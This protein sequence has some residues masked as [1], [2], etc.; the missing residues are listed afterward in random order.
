MLKTLK[1][2]LSVS[3]VFSL[4]FSALNFN[5]IKVFAGKSKEVRGEA[6]LNTI[7]KYESKIPEVYKLS[8]ANIPSGVDI[9]NKVQVMSL[10]AETQELIKKVEIQKVMQEQFK[11]AYR[12]G[13]LI[14]KFNRDESKDSI[15]EIVK[16]VGIDERSLVFMPT[17]RK[18]GADKLKNTVILKNIP[19]AD[20]LLKSMVDLK[21]TNR[22]SHVSLDTIS[23]ISAWENPTADTRVPGDFNS[24]IHWYLDKINLPKLWKKENCSGTNCLGSLGVKVAVMDTGV[25]IK[26]TPTDYLTFKYHNCFDTNNDGDTNDP[27]ECIDPGVSHESDLNMVLNFTKASEMS[28]AI[29]RLYVQ[30]YSSYEPDFCGNFGFDAEMYFENVFYITADAD[31]DSD[32]HVGTIYDENSCTTFGGLPVSMNRKKEGYPLDD[33]GHGTYIASTILSQTDNDGAAIGVAGNV[34]LV[35]IKVN[36]PFTGYISSLPVYLGTIYAVDE[37][38]VDIINMSFGGSSNVFLENAIGYANENNVLVIAASGNSTS[39]GAVMYPAAYSGYYS[40]EWETTFNNVIAVGASDKNDSRAVYSHYGSNLDLVAPVGDGGV[41]GDYMTQESIT[42]HCFGYGNTACRPVLNTGAYRKSYGVT[43]VLGDGYGTSYASAQVAAAAALIKSK[44]P[45]VTPKQIRDLL[46]STATDLGKA[47]RDDETGW[48]NLNVENLMN[49]PTH[50]FTYYQNSGKNKTAILVG[51]KSAI[52]SFH[53]NIKVGNSILQGYAIAGNGRI[54]PS[55]SGISAGPVVIYGDL[56]NAY[57]TERAEINGYFNEYAATSSSELTNVYY[58]TWYDNRKGTKT[59]IL[60]GNPSTT[61]TADVNIKINKVVNDNFTLA[62]NTYVSK[63][64][65]DV[66]DGPVTVSANTNIYASQRTFMRGVAFNEYAG[67]PF[68]SLTNKYYFTWY[69]QLG[70]GYKATILVGNP[71]TNQTA[72]VAIKIAGVLRGTYQ[73]APGGRITPSYPGVR[74]GPVVV[75]SDINV[76]A[77][78]RADV[79]GAFNEYAGIPANALSNK[80]YFT[81]YDTLGSGYTATTLVANPSATTNANVTIKIA[82]ITKGTYVIAPGGIVTPTYAGVR[83]GPVV[84]ESD[85]EIIA[86]QRAVVKGT[87]NE[88]P[89]I[90]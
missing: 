41:A 34:Q 71:S 31:N 36:M 81:W 52:D 77:T 39:G 4:L 1:C 13:I 85:I 87:F 30:P 40:R 7:P 67:I 82:G 46:R 59:Y 65:N 37:A 56:N 20:A 64:Y 76:Y 49:P 69:D 53:T 24:S 2:F 33:Y 54:T 70:K 75:E 89:G 19:N 68:N 83:N 90:K 60:V 47:G 62:P 58:F 79:L 3:I 18:K 5:E 16:S 17:P 51:N 72:N 29:D 12:P 26:T 28:D 21:Y 32:G 57:A 9:K 86:S 78:Q 22:V 88:Y 84:V 27:D 38:E 25:A 50:Y 14:V 15:K 6:K 66:L 43:T 63:Q 10:P 73:I 48:G 8:D 44:D 45:T 35:P 11:H 23:Y 42:E 61:E 80:Y 55:Y 74:G